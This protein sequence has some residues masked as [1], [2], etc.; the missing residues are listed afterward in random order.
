MGQDNEKQKKD[1]SQKT[2][3]S[4]NTLFSIL[5][6]LKEADGAGVTE[7]AQEVGMSKGA[8]HRYLT[9]LVERG[10]AVK[11]EGEYY[12]GLRFL[13]FGTYIRSQYE[14]DTVET[15]VEQL[16]EQ[17]GERSQFIVEEHGQGIYRYRKRGK[18]A[19][20]TDARVGKVVRLHTIA[21][22]K[23][24][25]AHL[26]RERVEQIID[27]YG[28]NRRS[29]NTITKRRELYDELD[30]IRERGY[31]LNKDEHVVGLQGV[32]VP[33]KN[34]DGD[35][36]GGLSVS[37]PTYRVKELIEQGDIPDILLGVENEIELNLKYT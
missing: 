2:V 19:V 7:V 21:A 10:Y 27:K 33:I 34:A 30:E 8:L 29:E 24:I 13:G 26:P 20:E 31:A 17:T 1:R 16:A 14:F 28:L 22:G 36:L 23:A 18:N 3:Q 11:K 5:E 35:V 12:L 4:V 15:K 9:T 32:G 6:Y 37:G 25:L